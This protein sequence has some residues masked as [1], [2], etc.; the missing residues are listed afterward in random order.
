MIE[1][2]L[3]VAIII[4]ANARSVTP[5]SIALLQK[6]ITDEALFISHSEKDAKNIAKQIVDGKFD[7]VLCGGGDGTFSR[8][9]TDIAEMTKGK[10]PAFGVLRLGTGNGMSEALNV[11]PF[12][13]KGIAAELSQA[14]DGDARVTKTLIKT[15]GRLTPF[16]GLGLDAWILGDYNFVKKILNS[17]PFLPKI[18]RGKMDY[19]LAI[20]SLSG[21]RFALSPMPIITVKNGNGKAYRIDLEGERSS[22][23]FKPGD[24]IFDGPAA[25]ASTSTVPYFGWGLRLFPQ[26]NSLYKNYF[27]LRISALNLMESLFQWPALFLGGIEHEKIH[28]FACQ[29][30]TIEINDPHYPKGLPLQIS[31]DSA[32]KHTGVRLELAKITAVRG[33]GR[34]K[35]NW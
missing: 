18:N 10:Q 26:V 7:V 24:V 31:G 4:N 15:N 5:V 29:D 8:C 32:G 20:M 16:A 13:P 33:S 19:A 9:V 6:E 25:I 23:T 34:H 27:Q 28:D 35:N 11:A 12:S 17:I 14:K 21:W 30:I 1:N 2:N 22:A 3:R